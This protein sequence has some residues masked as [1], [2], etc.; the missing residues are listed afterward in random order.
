MTLDF[1]TLEAQYIDFPW[2]TDTQDKA[3]SAASTDHLGLQWA[4][5]DHVSL[6]LRGTAIPLR[7]E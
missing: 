3:L 1:K 7:W 6:M 5:N 2:D 4:A